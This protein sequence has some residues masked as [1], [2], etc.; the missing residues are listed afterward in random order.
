MNKSKKSRAFYRLTA[1]ILLLAALM[2]ML[3]SCGGALDLLSDDL[4]DYITLTE[5]DYKSFTVNGGIEKYSEDALIR[6]INSILAENRAEKPDDPL[7]LVNVPITLGD[8]VSVYY[9]GYTVDE[10]GV[11]TPIANACNFNSSA[12]IFTVGSGFNIMSSVFVPG[13]EEAL[14]GKIPSQYGK[15]FAIGMGKPTEDMIVYLTYYSYSETTNK[16][17]EYERLDLARE[18]I[19]A[20]YGDGF[21]EFILSSEI[22]KDLGAKTFEKDG[23]TVGYQGIK[24]EYA[25]DFEKNPIT[26]D[27]TFPENC[28]VKE[29]RGTAAKFDLFVDYTIVYAT[30][31]LDADFITKKLGV[32]ESDLSSY[33]GA[34]IVEKYKSKLR[35]EVKAEIDAANNRIIEE[36]LW[37][38]YLKKTVVKELPEE[39]LDRCYDSYYNEVNLAY[40]Y[41]KDNFASLD[42]CAVAYLNDRYGLG[43]SKNGDWHAALEAYSEEI[44]LKQLIFYYVIREESFLPSDEKLEQLC[45]E[46]YEE[47]VAEELAA[48]KDELEDL[49]KDA[50]ELYVEDLR[51]DVKD[52]YGDSYFR[53]AAYHRYGMEK[54][55]TFAKI[56]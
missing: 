32:K 10:K 1:L 54:L 12:K 50:Y 36:A 30:D 29:L 9:R 2:P 11:Q 35:E 40:E 34:D 31:E 21:L 4:S 48:Q 15:H 20:E 47:K 44:V 7:G 53:Q 17:V 8:E 37:A 42:E 28:P 43:I 14:V 39:E 27:V 18:G 41:N 46:I 38:H 3:F 5:A 45:T 19:D 25:T 52:Y 24:I 13:V 23:K 33:T 16:N 22:G 56:S 6:K 51:K 49:D 26:V 55:Y